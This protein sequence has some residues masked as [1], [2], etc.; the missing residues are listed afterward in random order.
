MGASFASPIICIL[1]L[2][3]KQHIE[4]YQPMFLNIHQMLLNILLYLNI[5]TAELKRPS[6]L[7]LNLNHDKYSENVIKP[8]VFCSIY[9]LRKSVKLFYTS[10][11]SIWQILI[12]IFDVKIGHVEFCDLI[13]WKCCQSIRILH[14]TY[15][16]SFVKIHQILLTLSVHKKK[17]LM[18]N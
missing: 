10:S 4:F 6:H 11:W 12:L 9:I 14:Y 8:W 5:I 18:I 17:I 2:L 1:Q 16:S 13:F 7:I 3:N 15:I